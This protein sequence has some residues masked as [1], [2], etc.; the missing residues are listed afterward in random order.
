MRFPNGETKTFEQEWMASHA[1]SLLGGKI[2][3]VTTG[4]PPEAD[5]EGA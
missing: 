5:G 4:N 2:T 3:R 1:V